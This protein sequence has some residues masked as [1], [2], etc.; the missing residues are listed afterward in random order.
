V[1]D[2]LRSEWLRLSRRRDIR[3][4]LV[5]LPV[6][7]GIQ[8]LSGHAGAVSSLTDITSD[9][10]NEARQQFERLVAAYQAPRSVATILSS[11]LLA[12]AAVY[13]GVA[14]LGSEYSG[15]TIKTWL[16]VAGSR[17]GFVASHALGV[18]LVCAI[19][20]VELVVTGLALPLVITDPSLKDPGLPVVTIIDIAAVIA[21]TA[22]GT[23]VLA[24]GAIL[25][26]T[27]T[28][29]ATVA[30]V[31]VVVYGIVEP[32]ASASA[33]ASAGLQPID[34]LPVRQILSL[35]DQAAAPLLGASVEFAL[36]MTVGALVLVGW[37][38]LLI[39]AT[40]LIIWLR[41]INE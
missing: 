23:I 21:A 2:L 33:A 22:L 19:A 18:A 12:L 24:L 6:V 40:L 17:Y 25:A 7:A 39:G 30:L 36:P 1:S 41:D 5:L 3:L 38:T 4:L 8:F 34:L 27:V 26:A 31:L 16:Q 14:S 9:A 20:T 35:R 37:A 28:R 10:P 15:R 29:N 32:L 11:G 13:V